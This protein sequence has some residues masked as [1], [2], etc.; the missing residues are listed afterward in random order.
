M[1]QKKIFLYLIL[2]FS[3]FVF[4]CVDKEQEMA[5]DNTIYS[6]QEST[7]TISSLP[8]ESQFTDLIPTEDEINLHAQTLP[9]EKNGR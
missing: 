3:S 8:T 5:G 7:L 4:G 1:L 2:I 6:P 9:D